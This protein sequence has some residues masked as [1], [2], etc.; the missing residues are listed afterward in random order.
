MPVFGAKSLLP[1]L[2]TLLSFL[3]MQVP[4]FAEGERYEELIRQASLRHRVDP[5]LIKAVISQESSFNERA[6]GA[7]GE[8]GLMQIKLGAVQ[9][10]AEANEL[11]V[12]SKRNLYSPELNIEIGTWYLARA[13][14]SWNGY[15]ACITLALCEYNAGRRRVLEWRPQKD[16]PYVYIKSSSARQYVESVRDRF[17]TYYR[18]A[19]GNSVAVN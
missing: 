3:L 18:A 2:M 8:I 13:L 14:S 1:A 15:K 16:S 4:C 5:L 17:M 7:S 19:Y 12:P 9:D 10:W 6:T 11:P